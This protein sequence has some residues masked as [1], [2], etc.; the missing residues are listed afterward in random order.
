MNSE[1]ELDQS[2]LSSQHCTWH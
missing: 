1:K 2:E